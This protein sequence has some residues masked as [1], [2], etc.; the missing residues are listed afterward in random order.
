VKLRFLVGLAHKITEAIGTTNMP[1]VREQLGTLAAHA[2]MVEGLLFGIEASGRMRGDYYLPNRHLVYAA[3][4]TTQALYPL[5]VNLIR[6]L[7]GG[8]LIMLPS[9]LRDWEHPEIGPILHRTQRSAN[10]APEDKVKLLKAAWDAIGSEFGSRHT[11]YEMFYAGARF[12]ATGHSYRTYDW[13]AARG[14]VDE[15]LGGYGI[16]DASRP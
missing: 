9:S 3:Q 1:Q 8:A 2:G 4:V 12:V 15:L 14:M 13:G 16:E 6:D 7:A 10:F 5:L 11:Q